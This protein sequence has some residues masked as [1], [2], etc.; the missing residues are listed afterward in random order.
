MDELEARVCLVGSRAGVSR[1]YTAVEAASKSRAP[2]VLAREGYSW[3]SAASVAER[4]SLWL[5]APRARLSTRTMGRAKRPKPPQRSVLLA[6]GAMGLLKV[7]RAQHRITIL[8][9]AVNVGG[10]P[11][12]VDMKRLVEFCRAPPLEASH[13]VTYLQSG[14]LVVVSSHA[15]DEAASLVQ[16]LLAEEMGAQSTCL[17]RQADDIRQLIDACPY[18]TSDPTKVH[19]AFLAA[20]PSKA[21]VTAL[22]ALDTGDDRYELV[23]RHL[24]LSLPNGAGRA[25]LTGA[26]LEKALGVEVTAR[27][28]RTVLEL[29]EMVEA[30]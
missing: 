30:T 25:K 24:Y 19:V 4:Q 2:G 7:G 22:A 13:A 1:S 12:R 15:P 29:A 26:R 14:N 20:E 3:A 17:A 21:G 27:N 18:E 11:N 28:W 16:D 10:S 8:M 9:R 5:R 23:D 6:S